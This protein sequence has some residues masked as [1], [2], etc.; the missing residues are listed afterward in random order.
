MINDFEYVPT[1][2]DIEEEEQITSTPGNIV[3]NYL[4]SK[5]TL[6]AA[7]S[8]ALTSSY[9]FGYLM[10]MQDERKAVIELLKLSGLESAAK[11]LEES[12]D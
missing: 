11:F 1:P 3:S 2:I 10:G 8:D 6:D 5:N 4:A 7:T 12:D 9:D